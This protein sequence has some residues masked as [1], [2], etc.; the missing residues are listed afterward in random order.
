MRTLAHI[1]DIHFGTVDEG[2]AEALAREL[3]ERAPSLLIASGD[4][5]QRARRAQ[6][7]AARDYLAGLPQPQL[8]V[9]GNHDIP[10]FDVIRRFFFPLQRYRQYITRD[11]RPLYQDDWMLVLGINTAR[12]FVRDW[13]AFW[14]GGRISEEQLLDVELRVCSAPQHLFKVIVTHHPFLPAPGQQH[15]DVVQK[16][17]RA[18]ATLEKC[19]VDLLLAGH[20]HLNYT[21]EIREHHAAVRRSMI[22]VHAGTATSSRKRGEPNSYNWIELR[23]NEVRIEVRGWN[24]REFVALATTRYTR[25]AE[26]N[27]SRPQ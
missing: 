27:W 25:D 1:S 4:L 12:P 7:A 17:A 26:G 11:L 23:E 20:L 24:G 18:L 16:P 22:S 19:G 3:R 5:T 13:R 14:K 8:A 9:P 21:G 2:I 15:S 6:Y 10:L